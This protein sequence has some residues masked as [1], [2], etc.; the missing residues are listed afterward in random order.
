MLASSWEKIRGLARPNGLVRMN[1]VIKDLQLL[2][3][4]FEETNLC[5][6]LL[7]QSVERWRPGAEYL[8]IWCDACLSADD[9]Q[10]PGM[11]FH[12][13]SHGQHHRLRCRLDSSTV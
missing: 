8:S 12:Y 3:Q 7:E 1:N 2:A 9:T 13:F 10:M 6:A 5:L 11:G 4:V